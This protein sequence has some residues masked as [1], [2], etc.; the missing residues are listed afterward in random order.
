MLVLI[1][2]ILGTA[3]AFTAVYFFGHAEGEFREMKKSVASSNRWVKI[4]DAYHD[5][6][7]K[8]SAICDDLQNEN[9]LLRETL[10]ELNE[11]ID[12]HSS[13]QRIAK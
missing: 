10:K 4:C 12:N 8:M 6:F 2:T 1:V 11:S 5:N 3:I 9:R 7:E 13:S